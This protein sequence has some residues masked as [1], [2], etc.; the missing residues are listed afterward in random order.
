MK[1]IFELGLNAALF[2]L[3]AVNL[4]FAQDDAAD[5]FAA[6]KPLI[7]K[8]WK[9]I[10]DNRNPD[11][12]VY[13]IS[14]FEL[15]LSG[16]A[17]RNLHSVNNGDYGGETIIYWDK[18]QKNLVYYYFTTAGFYTHGTFTS[19]GGKIISHEFVE[20]NEQGITEVKGISEITPEGKLSVKTLYFKDGKWIDGRNSVYEE[21][22]EPVILK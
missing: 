6:F 7:G 5:H 2:I 4:N 1:N 14:K 11:K 10:V 20:G 3:L 19:E 18:V 16:Q 22:N 21:T 8:T 13:D 15:A 17:V 9:G 12:P